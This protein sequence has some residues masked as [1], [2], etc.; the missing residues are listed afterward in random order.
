MGA[1]QV[2]RSSYGR[3][4]TVAVAV[5]ALLVVG[6]AALDRPDDLSVVTAWAVWGTGVVAATFWRP[7]LVVEPSGV[8]VVNVLATVEV[9]W[10]ALHEVRLRYGL[11]LV[12][13]GGTVGVWATPPAAR[14][15]RAPGGP[16]PADTAAA[17]VEAGARAAAQGG[18]DAAGVP[19]TR[20][21]RRPHVGTLAGGLALPLLAVVAAA[22][23]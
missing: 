3:G 8:R 11:E 9:P 10:A 5:L 12:T 14:T 23:G 17:A 1:T 2:F 18:R 7:A 13:T 16:G 6:A 15:R 21:V 22:L 20:V 4:L 19:S